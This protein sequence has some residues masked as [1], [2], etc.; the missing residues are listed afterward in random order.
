MLLSTYAQHANGN[1]HHLSRRLAP[2]AVKHCQIA[3]GAQAGT[4]KDVV[5]GIPLTVPMPVCKLIHNCSVQ[6]NDKV[7]VHCA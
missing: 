6:L 4:T 1:V 7:D 2:G 5:T 3:A